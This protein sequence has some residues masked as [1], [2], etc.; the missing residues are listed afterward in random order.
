MAENQA[1]E[2]RS[3]GSERPERRERHPSGG[4][5]MRRPHRKVCNFC[6]DKMD[7]IDYKDVENLRKFVTESGKIMPRRMSGV[8]A[9]HQRDLAIAIKRARIAALLPY[10]AE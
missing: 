10:V 2:V 1:A 5:G 4:R 9:K 6:V 7:Y 8:C 3:E